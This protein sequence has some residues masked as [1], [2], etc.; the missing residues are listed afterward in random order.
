MKLIKVVIGYHAGVGVTWVAN[1]ICL[2]RIIKVVL[3]PSFI[4]SRDYVECENLYVR[5]MHV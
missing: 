3:Y 2:K 4:L 5:E 1:L